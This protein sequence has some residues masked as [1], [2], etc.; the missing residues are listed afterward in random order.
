MP[1]ILLRRVTH[2]NASYVWYNAVIR[3]LISICVLACHTLRRTTHIFIMSFICVIDTHRRTYYCAVS[4]MRMPHECL[5]SHIYVWL[6]ERHWYIW[7][8]LFNECLMNA[9]CHTYIAWFKHMNDTVQR[10]MYL[11]D[12]S[13]HSHQC[14]ISHIWM[15]QV[16]HVN[17]SWMPHA[18]DICVNDALQRTICFAIYHI[19]VIH[20]CSIT[21]AYHTCVFDYCIVSH[22]RIT[23]SCQTYQCLISHIWMPHVTHVNASCL[24][25]EWVMSNHLQTHR[26]YKRALYS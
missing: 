5:M 24:P 19:C 9:S 15:P 26:I 3:G 6:E 12:T 20:M 11:Y 10:T 14:L 8:T 13:Y 4:H 1:H 23:A 17:A 22:I 7:K 18:I 2:I 21:A 16:T 25:H